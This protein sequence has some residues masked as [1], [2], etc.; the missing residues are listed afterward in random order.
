MSINVP[1]EEYAKMKERC[2]GL[3]KGGRGRSCF[4]TEWPNMI[5]FLLLSFLCW[6]M[7]SEVQK[8]RFN[9]TRD[10]SQQAS[11]RIVNVA[12]RYLSMGLSWIQ[13]NA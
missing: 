3:I 1:A 6:N 2:V 4:Q 5:R 7:A 8:K 9:K 11:G 12:Q 10:M 13:V